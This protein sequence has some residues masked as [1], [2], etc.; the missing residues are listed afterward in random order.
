MSESLVAVVDQGS[1][2]TKGALLDSAGRMLRLLTKPVEKRVEGERHEHDAGQ[3]ADDVEA[4]LGTLLEDDR[5]ACIGLTCQRSTCLLWDRQSGA[6]LGP[7]RS[8]QD[9]SQSSRVDTLANGAKVADEI[10]ERTGLLLSPHYAAPK[11]AALV[12]ETDSRERAVDGSVVVGTLDAFLAQR[13]TGE[14]STEPGH[15]GRTLLYNLSGGEW[16]QRL[17]EIFDLPAAALPRLLPSAAGRGSY[18]G[19]PLTA[20]AGDQQAA[21]LGHGGWRPG[22]SAAHFGTGA[23]VLTSTGTREVRSDGLLS[24]ILASTASGSGEIR[25]FQLEGSVNSAG[26]AAD[27]ACRLSGERLEDWA[28]RQ[29]DI[30]HLPLVL[31]S[32]SGAAAPWWRPTARAAF[33]QLSLDT[34]PSALLAAT[35]AGVAMRVVDCLEALAQAGVSAHVL[36]V[37]GKL[38]RLSGLVELLA[39]TAQLPVEISADEEAGLTGI[40]KLAAV[41][42]GLD[43]NVLNFEPPVRR[44][45]E[46]SWPSARAAAVRSRWLEFVERALDL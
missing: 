4:I 40:A 1:T 26:S 2:Q 34:P 37:S 33:S 6:P 22:V 43:E 7:A 29:I 36:R 39:N 15:A 44:R 38:T 16:D 31:P 9:R 8:W 18:R 3:I 17:L 12:D 25:R 20:L 46:P 35:L 21:L 27:W 10:A 45:V 28:D 30:E 11:L 24:A 13:L 5:V 41:G 14:A 19:V 42:A 23:F 32:F